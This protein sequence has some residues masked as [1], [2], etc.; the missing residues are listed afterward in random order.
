MPPL[1]AKIRHDALVKMKYRGDCICRQY[2]QVEH[3][4]ICKKISTL[5]LQSIFQHDDVITN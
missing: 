5:Q 3:I 2:S 1:I 4:K